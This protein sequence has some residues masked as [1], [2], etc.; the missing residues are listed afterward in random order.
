MR[1]G[2]P[3]TLGPAFA[4]EGGQF[5]RPWRSATTRSAWKKVSL[6]TAWPPK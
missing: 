4:K 1:T 2:L 6:A 5:L 3:P